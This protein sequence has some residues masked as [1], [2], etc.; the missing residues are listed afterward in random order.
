[1]QPSV[2]EYF[3]EYSDVEYILIFIA[4]EVFVRFNRIQSFDRVFI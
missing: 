2:R 4:A 3:S 1:M